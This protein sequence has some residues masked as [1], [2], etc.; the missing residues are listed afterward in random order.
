LTL[1]EDAGWKEPPRV[2]MY[3]GRLEA[4]ELDALANRVTALAFLRVSAPAATGDENAT[5]R[6]IERHAGSVAAMERLS[7]S[8]EGAALDRAGKIEFMLALV[9]IAI[10]LGGIGLIVWGAMRGAWEGHILLA[11]GVVAAL[12]GGLV[13][14]VNVDYLGMR[15]IYRRLCRDIGQRPDALVSSDEPI[16]QWVD[17]V[18]RVQWHQLMPDKAADRGLL[19]IDRTHARLLFEGVKERYVI[20]ADAVLACKVVPMLPHT[21][22]WNYF[23]VVL[24]VRYPESAPTSL[25]GGRRDDQWE[26]PLLPRP[27]QFRRYSSAHRRELAKTLLADIEELL[28]RATG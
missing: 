6:S 3:Q 24:T 17:I 20:P 18:P 8:A 15:F 12:A 11:T 9:P 19:A 2:L 14:C 10:L 22:S 27:T 23:A 21:G 26:I 5:G 28:D 1:K 4:E 25:I 13:C 7:S 16:A